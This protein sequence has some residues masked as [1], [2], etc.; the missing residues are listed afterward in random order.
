MEAGSRFNI[1]GYVDSISMAADMIW[2]SGEGFRIP[3]YVPPHL[4]KKAEYCHKRTVACSGFIHC[5]A[6]YLSAS[7]MYSR[8]VRVCFVLDSVEVICNYDSIDE[9][10]TSSERTPADNRFLPGT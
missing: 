3:V 7:D 6:K 5:F 8:K 1:V 2:V 4:R 10:V 9:A